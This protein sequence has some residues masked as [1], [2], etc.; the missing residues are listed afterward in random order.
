LEIIMLSHRTWICVGSLSCCALLLATDLAYSQPAVVDSPTT[1]ALQKLPRKQGDRVAVTIYEFRSSVQAVSAAAATDMFK[2]ALV[3]S[4]QFRVV[5]RARLNQGAVREKQLNAQGLTSGQSAQQQLRAAEYVF[6]GTISEANAS[7]SQRSGGI[8]IAGMEIGGGGNTDTL[9]IDVR[10]VSVA[11]GD[12]L[13][14]IAVSVPISS[15]SSAVSGVGNL[16]GSVLAQRG[17]NT[18]YAP[19]VHLQ[20]SSREGVD[21][22]LRSAI[23]KAVLE[24]AR[25]FAP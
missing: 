2:T 19:D 7:T 12:I 14:A 15:S 18:T 22:A 13:D 17:A 11:N 25:R 6:E 4:G 21:S 3:A 8:N 1:R 10:V 24:L 20:T 9:A 23:D 5:E 16:L